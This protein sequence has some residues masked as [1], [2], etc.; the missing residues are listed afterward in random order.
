MDATAPLGTDIN[1]LD[2]V[3]ASEF[4]HLGERGAVANFGIGP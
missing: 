3:Q 4:E 1:S 2:Q